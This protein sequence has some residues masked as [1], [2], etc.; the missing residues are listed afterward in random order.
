MYHRHMFVNHK[1]CFMQKIS[2]YLLA[3]L[4]IGIV[5]SYASSAQTVKNIFDAE[6]PVV[7]L[8]IDFTQAKIIGEQTEP[9]VMRDKEFPGI[10]NLIIQSGKYDIAG[11]LRRTDIKSD[12]SEVTAH[13]Q[14]IDVQQ[15]R[16]TLPGDFTHVTVNDINKLV[17]SYAFKGKTGIGLLLVV[18]GMSKIEK[19][20]TIYVTFISMPTKKV[21]LAERLW[22][23]GGGFGFRNYWAKSIEELVNKIQTSKYAE[24]K[25]KYGA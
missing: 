24:W 17:R 5:N 25:K 14:K 16:S 23:N 18:D 3:F 1:T 20:A 22:G 10:N 15:I 6:T 21:L 13:N 7:Y 4:L 2:K 11:A 12:L 8:G 9:A 19:A